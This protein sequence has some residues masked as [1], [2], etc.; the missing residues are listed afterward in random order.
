VQQNQV[1][2]IGVGGLAVG[3]DGLNRELAAHTQDRYAAF[4]I[5]RAPDLRVEVDTEREGPHRPGGPPDVVRKSERQFEISYGALEA[6]LDLA[7]GVGR[8]SFPSSIWMVDSLLRMSV[9]LMLAE[10]GGLLLHGSGVQLADGVLVCFGPS[11]VGKTTVARSVAPETV[12]CDEMIALVPEGAGVRAHGTPFHGDYSI[13]APISGPVR[14]LV[15]LVQGD[16]DVLHPLSTAQAAQALLG[17]T[18]FFCRDEA[19]SEE[20]LSTALRTCSR[21]T[22]RLTFQRGT[23]V[24]SFIVQELGLAAADPVEEDARAPGRR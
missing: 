23:H 1:I 19:L 18:L 4:L 17:S 2:V 6:T 3:L 8:A 21:R 5:D 16:D 12:L 24:P 10:R 13:C 20:L 14:A 7:A 11:G 15:R 22:Y 9:G